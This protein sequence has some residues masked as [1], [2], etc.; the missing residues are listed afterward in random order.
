[1]DDIPFASRGDWA[2]TDELGRFGLEM[3]GNQ[4]VDPELELGSETKNFSGHGG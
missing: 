4:L 1:M 2:L 3:A